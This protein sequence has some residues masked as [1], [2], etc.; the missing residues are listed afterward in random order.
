MGSDGFDGELAS[1]APLS[2]NLLIKEST[3]DSASGLKS[4]LLP[5]SPMF[6]MSVQYQ[7]PTF[8][9]NPVLQSASFLSFNAKAG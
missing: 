6:P 5:S 8:V 1:L 9:K 4:L 2:S 3:A 7:A